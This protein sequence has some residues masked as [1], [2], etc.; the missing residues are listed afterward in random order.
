LA[1][2]AP[3][4]SSRGPAASSPEAPSPAARAAGLP[5]P[6]KT[7]SGA[8]VPCAR[9]TRLRMTAALTRDEVASLIRIAT[10]EGNPTGTPRPMQRS[11]AQ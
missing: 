9:A 1:C 8:D 3:R 4:S 5:T 7:P 6:S 10:D 11:F 2:S